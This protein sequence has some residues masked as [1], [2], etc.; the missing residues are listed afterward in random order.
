MKNHFRKYIF[1]K[2]NKPTIRVLK[3]V[4]ALITG[5]SREIYSVLYENMGRFNMYNGM[6]AYKLVESRRITNEETYFGV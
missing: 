1:K 4:D 3:V 6:Y 2:I 5:G